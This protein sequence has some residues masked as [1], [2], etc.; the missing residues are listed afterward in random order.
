MNNSQTIT[1][2]Q[3]HL[4][5]WRWHFLAG[6]YV[7]PFLIMLA[8][9]GMLMMYSEPF[10]EWRLRDRSIVEPAG[11]SF[12]AAEQLAVVQSTYAH[13]QADTY[14]PPIA[15]NRASEFVLSSI[16][17]PMADGHGEH[18][19]LTVYVNPYTNTITGES[20]PEAT[21]YALGNEI[22]GTLLI[23]QT[24]DWMI[25]IAAGLAVLLVLSGF[26]LW[27]PRSGKTWRQ[28]LVP[29]FGNGLGR[30]SLWRSLHG[31][32][33]LWSAAVLMLFLVTG[34]SWTSVWGG[35]AQGFS[36]IPPEEFSG[37]VSHANHASLNTGSLNEVPWVLEKTPLPLS[38]MQEGSA[39]D[40]PD[41][42]WIVAYAR[43]NGFDN[44][45]VHIPT[46]TEAVW[47]IARSTL[48]KDDNNPFVDR[49][50]HLDRYNGK[51]VQ[52]I[53][54]FDYP[55]MGKF[56]A[57]GVPLH[58]G[59]VTVVN[60]IFNTIFCLAIIL[61]CVAG[62]IMWWQRRPGMS[63]RLA[64]PPMPSNRR[65]WYFITIA[66]LIVAVLVPLSLLFIVLVIVCE[67]LVAMLQR[68]VRREASE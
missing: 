61:L 17:A 67:W 31:S 48:A 22:H 20:N 28:M 16:H 25:E 44:F 30:R 6:L 66:V 51:V 41:L 45:R 14:R 2:R 57:A 33:G 49:M 4:A 27:W 3:L 65:V 10:D 62:V 24:G 52:E 21:L 7:V 34:L 58:Q 54:Y 47:T 39:E 40:L 60:L 43:T 19:L 5:I 11:T 53:R 13:H 68:R 55:A 23:G 64:P 9:T 38:S 42:D 56:M 37:P 36:Y 1:T 46:S 50:I 26:Y 29:S 12:S 59:D 8:L 18:T 15:P 32:I 63:S 35:W